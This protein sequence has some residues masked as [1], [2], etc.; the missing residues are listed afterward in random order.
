MGAPKMF[1]AGSGGQGILLMGQMIGAAAMLEGKEATFFPSYGPEMRGGTANCTVIVSDKPISSPLIFESDCVVAM[2]LPSMHK[3]EQTLKPGG[4]L[5]LNTSL[6]RHAPKRNDI[7]VIEVPVTEL[8]N[9][10]GNSRVANIIM[11]GAFIR[12]TNVVSPENIEKIIHDV[13][14]GQRSALLELNLK[15]FNFW[16]Q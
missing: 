8:A 9:E 6:I 14:S 3:F 1:F 11:L 4:L 2:T 12:A 10:L 5:M 16:Q 15:A 7:N 13:F